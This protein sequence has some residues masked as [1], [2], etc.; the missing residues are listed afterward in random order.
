MSD[1]LQGADPI[2]LIRCTVGDRSYALELACVRELVHIENLRPGIPRSGVLGWLL[3]PS[4][5]VPVYSG[6]VLFEGSADPELRRGQIILLLE[7]AQQRFG[8][9]VDGTSRVTRVQRGAILPL[10]ALMQD[11]LAP[12]FDGVVCIE[13][14]LVLL[15]AADRLVPG[16]VP[17]P[18]RR[19]GIRLAGQIW[20]EPVPASRPSNGL[21]KLIVFEVPGKTR[22]DVRCRLALSVLQAP[23]ILLPL[24]PLIVP[25]APSF[26]RG[27][28]V[29]RNRPLPVLDLARL[30]RLAHDSSETSGRLLLARAPARAEFCTIR[31]RPEVRIESLPLPHRPST[32][33]LPIPAS[34]LKGVFER[35]GEIL[36]LPDLDAILTPP[37]N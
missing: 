9:L 15:L 19:S 34:L 17:A 12:I 5:K 23:E 27:L 8:L 33:K 31:I 18:D 30:L 11:P 1:R 24:A 28:V 6:R 32:R 14:E 22:L 13:D 16:A 4:G 37:T 26:V 7:L 25:T 10:P 29:W 20:P 36:V 35:P 2:E 3:R 21:Q